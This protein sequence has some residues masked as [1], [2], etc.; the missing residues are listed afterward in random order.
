MTMAEGLDTAQANLFLQ[1]GFDLSRKT[2]TRDSAVYFHLKAEEIFAEA[3]MWD[4]YIQSMA[5]RGKMK[6]F[7][8]NFHPAEK[9]LTSADSIGQIHL[10]NN[11]PSIA[12]V[13]HWTGLM[14]YLR[15][16]HNEADKI[17]DSALQIRLEAL[18]DS[19]AETAGTY[20]VMGLNFWRM[21]KLDKALEFFEESLR[22]RT[23]L[24]TEKNGTVAAVYNNIGLIY[25]QKGN[26]DLSLSK[27]QKSLSIRKELGITRSRNVGNNYMN[28][29]NLYRK[30]GN[31]RKALE[32][33]E[34]G[35]D[36]FIESV[37]ENHSSVGAMYVNLGQSSDDLG[38]REKARNYY[39]KA[40]DNFK[41]NY[42]EYHERIAI[43]YNRLGIIYLQNGDYSTS[44]THLHEALRVNKKV[45]GPVHHSISV[46]YS[47]LVEYYL[48]TEDYH[49]AL[50]YANQT[51]KTNEQVKGQE[52]PKRGT[53]YFKLAE[54]YENIDQK[55][56]AKELYLKGIENDRKFYGA[57][58]QVVSD[59]YLKLAQNAYSQDNN[60]EALIF[61]QKALIAN[62]S[63]FNSSEIKDF[64]SSDD[65]LGPIQALKILQAKAQFLEKEGENE[66]AL[67][68]IFLADKVFAT[69]RKAITSS[70]ARK[71]WTNFI[72]PLYEKGIHLTYQLYQE[73]EDEIWIEK[74]FSLSERSKSS[75]LLEALKASEAVQ[76]A[77]LP[78]EVI[79]LET[80]LK[81]DLS[82]YEDQIFEEKQA[83]EK[84]NK[85]KIA[86]WEK[87]L[88]DKKITYDSL[89]QKLEKE[90]PE[91]YQLK[92]NLETA[93][94]PEIQTIL[95]PGVALLSYFI[96]NDRLYAFALSRDNYSFQVFDEV[97]KFE[98]DIE[99]FRTVS[100]DSNLPFTDQVRTGYRLFWQLIEQPL[101]DFESINHLILIPDGKL[102]YLPFEL[103]PTEQVENTEIDYQQIPFLLLSYGTSYAYS[104]TLMLENTRTKITSNESYIGFAPDYP[105]SLESENAVRGEFEAPELPP[106]ALSGIKDE[107]ND[108]NSLFGGKTFLAQMA[109]EENF[110]SLLD[111]PAILHLAMHALV[112]DEEPLQSR[113]LFYQTDDGDST[114]K[115]EDSFLNAY[116]I[117]NLQL[118]AQL[119]VLSACNTGYG[120]IQRGEG[121]MSLSR[122]F[123]YAG[124]PSIVT[125]LWRAKDQPAKEIMKFFYQN[126]KEGLA[127][128]QAL[129]EAK[130]TYLQNADPLRSH[131]A[132]WANF[133]I[134]GDPKPLRLNSSNIIWSWALIGL[135][136]LGLGGIFLI[137]RK[138]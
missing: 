112:N 76:F 34:E 107:V 77:G 86:F 97:S 53:Y 9:I 31:Y 89:I 71:E 46:T 100:I 56:K 19:S 92:Y 44:L 83:G 88:F 74:A 93:S 22:I 41:V 15:S 99:N 26:F 43:V 16:Q 24:Y 84:A 28:I 50:H 126:L 60:S 49:K 39:L 25:L 101:K 113:L 33:Y 61:I 134:I 23:N 111:K 2:A 8:G 55:E 135:V 91:Y 67:E 130:I 125:S 64:P 27:F 14:H 108:A 90:Y 66:T 117:Y 17:L 82:A 78:D 11:H 128:D 70:Q 138:K 121:I 95:E 12:T 21:G 30:K 104:A 63:V 119:A 106:F 73:T 36:I 132:N 10:P 40:L 129:R 72:L 81:L 6:V 69:I 80:S 1:K 13:F 102:G 116:E 7:A 105:L 98:K 133:V 137:K 118:N 45:F 96:G 35:L 65:F 110:K 127:K 122:A 4:E 47:N 75:L 62:S 68:A 18:G 32:Q 20:N 85:E 123:M 115:K 94:I 79:Q 103:L 87:K 3:G 57:R 48:D 38:D 52:N 124:V 58:H 59:G 37:G 120:Q 131:P 42:G 136:L 5:N 114:R 109:T 51:L 54:V 29:G